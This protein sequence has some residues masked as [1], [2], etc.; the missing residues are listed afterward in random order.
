MAIKLIDMMNEYTQDLCTSFC[1]EPITI[2]AGKII[3]SC[4]ANKYKDIAIDA[5]NKFQEKCLKVSSWE[6]VDEVFLYFDEARNT[7]AKAISED[8]I[9]VKYYSVD[10]QNVIRMCDEQGFFDPVY[11][12]ITEFYN[13]VQ[14]ISEQCGLISEGLEEEKENRAK[15]GAITLSSKVTDAVKTQFKA[16]ILN[17]AVGLVYD[18]KN[19]NTKSKVQKA[20]EEKISS[21]FGSLKMNIILPALSSLE[22]MFSVLVSLIDEMNPGII[23]QPTQE[24]FSAARAIYNNIENSNISLEEKY[25]MARQ[26]VQLMPS[27]NTYFNQFYRMFPKYKLEIYDVAKKAGSDISKYLFDLEY[28]NI[29]K[30]FKEK[31]KT[32][33]ECLDYIENLLKN[34][35]FKSSQEGKIYNLV[36]DII[37][38]EAVS[39]IRKSDDAFYDAE[40]YIE[41]VSDRFNLSLAMRRSIKQSLKN[42]Q[43]SIIDLYIS[44]RLGNTLEDAEKCLERFSKY[45]DEINLTP[46]DRKIH[47]KK[48][49]SQMEYVIIRDIKEKYNGSDES[50][51]DITAKIDYIKE[52]YGLI[53][54]GIKI[55]E[56]LQERNKQLRTI[57]GI[58]IGSEDSLKESLDIINNN[59]DIFDGSWQF[60]DIDSLNNAL[61]KIKSF[62]SV[63][64]EQQKEKLVQEIYKINADLIIKNTPKMTY[65]SDYEEYIMLIQQLPLDKKIIDAKAGRLEWELQQFEKKCDNAKLVNNK[66]ANIFAQILACIIEIA[67]VAG[68]ALYIQRTIMDTSSAKNIVSIIILVIIVCC[69]IPMNIEQLKEPK[70]IMEQ[71]TQNGKYDFAKIV[72]VKYPNRVKAK[73]IPPNPDNSKK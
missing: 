70:K 10:Q 62:P 7:V 17:A 64:N 22:K 45:A 53:N 48:I 6:N 18:A 19:K 41:K 52:K 63:I 16:D 50:L 46:E 33:S 69:I 30:A 68:I 13:Q 2:P 65:H 43:S 3:Y 9:S 72:E 34:Y 32:P 36:A 56:A 14:L 61:E 20:A 27:D 54:D 28:N 8:A 23:I 42:A 31:T 60:N 29:E 4:L 66:S 1:G 21:L 51:K 25:D 47:N 67:I 58:E 55:Q 5:H 73:V 44:E 15:F 26:V 59:P 35:N 37:E 49:L 38:K 12:L 11:S 40:E 39:Q 57:K 71:L 24:E